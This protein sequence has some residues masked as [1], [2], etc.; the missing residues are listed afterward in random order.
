MWKVS[1][2]SQKYVERMF[3]DLRHRGRQG[4]L[5]RNVEVKKNRDNRGNCRKRTRYAV[6]SDNGIAKFAKIGEQVSLKRCFH[7][8]ETIRDF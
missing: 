1:L 5:V 2:L 4:T 7:A 6:R 8:I 3:Q